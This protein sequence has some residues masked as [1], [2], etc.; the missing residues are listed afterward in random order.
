[1]VPM[2]SRE[3]AGAHVSYSHAQENDASAEG[4]RAQHSALQAKCTV[5]AN[6]AAMWNSC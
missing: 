4:L 2:G 3:C 6:P 1:M 5:G